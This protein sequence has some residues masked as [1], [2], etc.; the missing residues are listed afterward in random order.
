MKLETKIIINQAT[1]IPNENLLIWSI[2][3]PFEIISISGN[4]EKNINIIETINSKPSCFIYIML[5]EIFHH[6]R[7][8]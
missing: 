3:N 7:L 4:P 8:H 6:S 5:F 2:I 1:I